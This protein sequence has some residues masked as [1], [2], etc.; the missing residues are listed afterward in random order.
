ML[1]YHLA[2]SLKLNIWKCRILFEIFGWLTVIFSP[3]KERN[4]LAVAWFPISVR[5]FSKLIWCVQCFRLP[6][7]LKI[8]EKKKWT[9]MR[10]LQNCSEHSLVVKTSLFH[11]EV[12]E[13][14][15]QPWLLSP[16]VAAVMAQTVGFLLFRMGSCVKCA[17]PGSQLCA[18]LSSLLQALRK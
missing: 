8:I 10:L 7:S 18:V 13:F 5:I 17:V 4:L 6:W 12:S 9:H 11:V 3:L 16:W 15:S 1:Y 14:N 2:K